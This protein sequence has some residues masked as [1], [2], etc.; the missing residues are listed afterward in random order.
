[1]SQNA[2]RVAEISK[3]AAEIAKSLPENLQEA[4]FNRA[5]DALS[6]SGAAPVRG[7]SPRTV[8]AP[9]A[10]AR[11]RKAPPAPTEESKNAVDVLV[12][13]IN[14]TA[15]PEVNEAS[16]GLDRAL[17][18]LRLAHTDHG[19]DGLTAI[20]I[21]KVLTE[22]FRHPTTHQAIRQALNGAGNYVDYVPQTTGA[23]IYRLMG[24]G[25]KYLDAGGANAEGGR[26]TEGAK[27][28]PRR[29]AS[30]KPKRSS[31]GENA[32]SRK[33]SGKGPKSMIEELIDEDFFKSPKAISDI[34]QQLRNKRG[35]SFKAT[36]L[37]PALVRLLRQKSLD[38][39]RNDSNQF[40]YSVPS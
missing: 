16:I 8:K 4:A 21:A 27:P 39:E 29:R 32:P 33:R 37:S 24:P 10:R 11:G 15:H 19:I 34:Q 2:D 28:K 9:S 38:R 20:Q 31:K 1:M 17:H 25:E 14:R 26:K 3:Q 30:K 6:E 5:F 13:K 36:D 40:E 12:A 22:K 7:A 18:L 23:A 35:V